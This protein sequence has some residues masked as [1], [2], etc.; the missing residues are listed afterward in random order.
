MLDQSFGLLGRGFRVV[1][2]VLFMVLVVIRVEDFGLS[3]QGTK[4]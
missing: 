3:V 4:T 1:P 2:G